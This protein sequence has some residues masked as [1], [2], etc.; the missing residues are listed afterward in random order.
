MTVERRFVES[1][2]QTPS[3]EPGL[4]LTDAGD[5]YLVNNDG[6]RTLV[7]AGGGSLT[8]TDGVT[9][10][11]TTELRARAGSV[12]DLGSGVASLN[13]GAISVVLYHA[14]NDLDIGSGIDSVPI[15]WDTAYDNSAD[16]NPI[17]EL[18]AGLGLTLA[19]DGSSPGITTEEAGIWAYT[20]SFSAPIDATLEGFAGSQFAGVGSGVFVCSPSVQRGFGYG[21]LMPLPAGAFFQFRILPTVAG[22]GPE[23]VNPYLVLV[24]LA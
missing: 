3:N 1:F 20:L 22:G 17:T 19:I 9:S 23:F 2:R 15:S 10:V 21:E 16:F 6:S 5:V 18:P 12:M 14:A 13:I 8:V 24:R 11:A 4:V 7:A